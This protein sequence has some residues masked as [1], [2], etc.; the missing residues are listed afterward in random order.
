MYHCEK[1]LV[2]I[3]YLK[4]CK[5]TSSAARGGGG[6]F[7]KRETIGEIGCCESRMPDQKH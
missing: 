2:C 6:S 3:M 1:L 7:E 4:K 5:Y